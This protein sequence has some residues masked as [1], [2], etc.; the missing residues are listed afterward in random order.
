MSA[1]MMVAMVPPPHGPAHF[2]TLFYFAAQ[3]GIDLTIV[4]EV[5]STS[6]I[7]HDHV[8]VRCAIAALR[9]DLVCALD[10]LAVCE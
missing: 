3:F 6:L 1:G 5:A 9:D 2:A 10:T 7:G 8:D 4:R